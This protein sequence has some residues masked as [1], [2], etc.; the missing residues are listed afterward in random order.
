MCFGCKRLCAYFGH[1]WNRKVYYNRKPRIKSFTSVTNNVFPQVR[2]LV[3]SGKKVLIAAH[4]NNAVDNVLMKLTEL[5]MPFLRIGNPEQA[6]CRYVKIFTTIGA[7]T[8]TTFHYKRPG[9]FHQCCR[10]K[11]C[12]ISFSTLQQ[13]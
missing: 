6:W 2:A 10:P 7:F 9:S 12:F 13:P 8:H 11:R 3:S 1:A 4:T 5:D